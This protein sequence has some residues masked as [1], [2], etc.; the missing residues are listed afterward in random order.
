MREETKKRKQKQVKIKKELD[1]LKKENKISKKLSRQEE[2]QMLLSAMKQ[3]NSIEIEQETIEQKQ[4]RR[5]SYTCSCGC[6]VVLE[7]EIYKRKV[8]DGFELCS[9]CSE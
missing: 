8:K 9:K 7:G 5:R 4:E 1:T 2:N 3:K 6:H